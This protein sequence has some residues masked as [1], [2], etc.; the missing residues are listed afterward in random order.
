[1]L[2]ALFTLR[3]VGRD[4]TQDPRIVRLVA[5]SLAMHVL[6]AFAQYWVQEIYYGIADAHGY[7]ED[8]LPIAEAMR[9]D[10]IGVA[11]ELFKMLFQL[12]AR[13]PFL[14]LGPGDSS[15]S[16]TALTSMIIFFVGD[17]SMIAVFLSIAIL[18]WMSSLLIARPLSES[19]PHH[20]RWLVYVSMMVVPSVVYWSS[21][22]IKEAFVLIGMNVLG[23]SI[24]QALIK[25]RRIWLIAGAIGL[26]PIAM[27]KAYVL[28][29]LVLALG[30]WV[31]V[32][33]LN[34]SGTRRKIPWTAFA[35]GSVTITGGLF[36]LSAVFPKFA[37]AN[38][39]ELAG[40]QQAAW[41]SQ[42][43]N[44]T[45]QIG[46]GDNTTIGE[47]LPHLPLALVNALF[48]PFFFEVHNVTIIAA[49]IE[50][51]ALT[52]LILTMVWRFKLPVARDAVLTSPLL[53]ASLTFALSFAFAVGLVT[54]NLGSLS[55]YRMPMVPFYVLSV[56]L[57]NH[58]LR[59]AH[60]RAAAALRVSR[61]ASF[62][63]RIEKATAPAVP[64]SSPRSASET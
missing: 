37:L 46:S 32:R 7:L 59:A 18:T 3:A 41:S 57:L 42:G 62:K 51:S 53:A 30:A 54:L 23:F 27:V 6:A 8:G 31:F 34:A 9:D 26:A 20:E 13:F 10:P 44:S 28:F 12:P 60:R 5:L 24:Y 45:V 58:R 29:P 48:R 2:L 14:Q 49:A 15:S 63:R 17:Y 38:L 4:R 39:G 11:P 16:M 22:V 61:V 55:R 50:T 35:I 36:A 43:G 21:G 56:L 52:V 64:I 40:N 33:R 47:Q 1:M 25:R 19:V